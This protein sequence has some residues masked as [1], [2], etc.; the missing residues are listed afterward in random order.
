MSSVRHGHG[1]YSVA[2]YDLCSKNCFGLLWQRN[3]WKR[4][5][6]P[7]NFMSVIKHLQFLAIW[8][9]HWKTETNSC[10]QVKIAQSSCLFLSAEA[11]SHQKIIVWHWWQIFLH[12]GIVWQVFLNSW[13]VF[14]LKLVTL[15]LS[16]TYLIF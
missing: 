2:R 4:W 8:S 11:S 13:S 1:N 15:L 7:Q 3:V 9:L 6:L 12:F 14:R 5:L 10:F 16:S